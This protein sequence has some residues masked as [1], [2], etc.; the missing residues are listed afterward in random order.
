MGAG[1]ER[2]KM[3]PGGR[4]AGTCSRGRVRIGRGFTARP[5]RTRPSSAPGHL[6]AAPDVAFSAA[7]VLLTSPWPPAAVRRAADGDRLH[8]AA[9]SSGAGRAGDGRRDGG[10]AGGRP[11]GPAEPGGAGPARARR[12]AGG[13]GAPGSTWFGES[14]TGRPPRRGL[15][16][17]RLAALS[18]SA[19]GRSAPRRDARR[20][21]GLHARRPLPGLSA[22]IGTTGPCGLAAGAGVRTSRRATCRCGP[23]ARYEVSRQRGATLDVGVMASADV[24]ALAGHPGCSGLL[25]ALDVRQATRRRTSAARSVPGLLPPPCRAPARSGGAPAQAWTGVW[26]RPASLAE[27][28]VPPSA[29]RVLARNVAARRSTLDAGRAF[30]SLRF[31]P[32]AGTSGPRSTRSSSLAWPRRWPSRGA[33]S[34]GGYRDVQTAKLGGAHGGGAVASLGQRGAGGRRFAAADLRL[35]QTTI[36]A[37]IARAVRAPRSR[38]SSVARPVTARGA[39]CSALIAA[40]SPSPRSRRSGRRPPSRAARSSR[41]AARRGT[42]ARRAAAARRRRAAAAGRRWARRRTS[43]TT[44]R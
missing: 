38:S 25:P 5:R 17:R 20:R 36:L 10:P 26:A 1:D 3:D 19:Q 30:R 42:T 29:E 4:S 34:R 39:G 28:E 27:A 23:A 16:G 15:A 12:G 32:V 7:L 2:G 6:P 13:T 22:G 14:R 8:G 31:W 43:F 41:R 11:A 40:D 18:G 35:G 9:P 33:A 37:G 21:D 24:A 44:A